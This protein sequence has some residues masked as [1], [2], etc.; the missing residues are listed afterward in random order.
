MAII[1]LL[2]ILPFY[3]PMVISIDLRILRVLRM[4]RLFRIFKINRYTLSFK[5]YCQSVQ[6]QS[7]A[8]NFI[9]VNCLADDDYCI[10]IDV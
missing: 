5:Y 3:L 8:V 9:N 10:C 6:K 4:I 2:A 1:D 7:T